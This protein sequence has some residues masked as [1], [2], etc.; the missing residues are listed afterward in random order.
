M[1]EKSPVIINGWGGSLGDAQFVD[2]WPEAIRL[3][4]LQR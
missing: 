3:P 2:I 4:F 1:A